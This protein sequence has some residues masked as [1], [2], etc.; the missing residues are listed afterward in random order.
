MRAAPIERL[1]PREVHS[2]EGECGERPGGHRRLQLGDRGLFDLRRGSPERVQRRLLRRGPPSSPKDARRGRGGGRGRSEDEEV[3]AVHVHAS[4]PADRGWS[5]CSRYPGTRRKPEDYRDRMCV[6]SPAPPETER[7]RASPRLDI[8][9]VPT[10]YGRW[11][12]AGM[13]R[14]RTSPSESA[15]RNGNPLVF[16]LK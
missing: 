2:H 14:R 6:T 1:D 4:P 11:R 7:G 16:G 15:I 9:L 8:S 5:P 3:P 13:A 12:P 10:R